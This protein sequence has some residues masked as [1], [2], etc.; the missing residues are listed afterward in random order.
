MQ[1][2][3]NNE[4]KTFENISKWEYLSFCWGFIKQMIKEKCKQRDRGR[5]LKVVSKYINRI[6][7]AQK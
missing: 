1:N 2:Q 4:N 6:L 7:S 5:D 3:K